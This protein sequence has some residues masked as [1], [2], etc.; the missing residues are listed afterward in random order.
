LRLTLYCGRC[1]APARAE[2]PAPV[3]TCRRCGLDTPLAWGPPAGPVE[4]C[5]AC[6][7]ADLY[8]ESDFPARLGCAVMLLCAGGFLWTENL[9]V[10]VVSGAVGTVLWLLLPKRTICYRCLAEHRGVAPN[11]AHQEYELA[12]A[13]RYADRRKKS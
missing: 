8:V 12:R 3:A 4:R 1:L 5:A 6:G 7:C 9:L 13:A 10:L 11:P 2:P